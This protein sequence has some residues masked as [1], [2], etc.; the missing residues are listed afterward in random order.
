M[1]TNRTQ[2]NQPLARSE[3]L[4][5]EQ[6]GAET[7][8]YDTESG[9]AHCLSPIAAAVF[10]AADG[11][12]RVEELVEVAASTTG[13]AVSLDEVE[14]A[15]AELDER[16]LLAP[17]PAG[18]TRR[19][20]MRRTAAATAAVSAVP[21]VTS[22]VTPAAAQTRTPQ[23]NCGASKCSSQSEG[24]KWCG[25]INTCPPSTKFPNS[26]SCTP[27]DGQPAPIYDSCECLR[28]PYADN[29][30][31]PGQFQSN[32]EP[33]LTGLQLGLRVCQQ[34]YGDNYWK[35]NNDPN[36][37]YNPNWRQQCT[38]ADVA[39]NWRYGCKDTSKPVDGACYNEPG[40]SSQAGRGLICE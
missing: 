38:A 9:G 33:P 13:D 16:R 15:L 35:V 11:S 40:D 22:I 34:L 28:C 31:D 20:M 14:V 12:S 27:F 36:G 5:I 8:V 1:A 19:A 30:T 25:C 32:M 39:A 29:S 37:A 23:L 10:A 6:V 4:M 7:V 17:P 21:M 18:M 3:G 24:D 26:S 2:E